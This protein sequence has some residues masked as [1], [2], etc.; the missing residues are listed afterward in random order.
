MLA[1]LPLLMPN[2]LLDR[3]NLSAVE[4]P[5][6]IAPVSLSYFWSFRLTN[7]AGARWIRSIVMATFAGLQRCMT[8][9]V[10]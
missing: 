7:D 6:P 8:P 1:T 2:E 4:P 3:S 9:P 5:L 10:T